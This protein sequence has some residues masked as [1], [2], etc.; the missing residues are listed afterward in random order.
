MLGC[1][2]AAFLNLGLAV[3]PDNAGVPVITVLKKKGKRVIENADEVL[4]TLQQAYPFAAFVTLSGE[5]V[6]SM[7]IR[8][9]VWPILTFLRPVEQVHA[10]P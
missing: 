10:D 9:Q 3:E 4:Q 8:D 5:D 2:S 7:P 6:A 1:R